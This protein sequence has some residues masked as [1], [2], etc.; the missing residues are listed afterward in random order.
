MN[1][2]GFSDP[3]CEDPEYCSI[4]EFETTRIGLLTKLEDGTYR[5]LVNFDLIEFYGMIF[6]EHEVIKERDLEQ[7]RRI[8]INRE[9]SLENIIELYG[10]IEDECGLRVHDN[11]HTGGNDF[12]F[13]A[14]LGREHS[15]YIHYHGGDNYCK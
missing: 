2:G 15:E 14:T 3:D 8:D 7:I 5:D 12:D 10:Y 11:V 13:K 9:V 1:Y 4:K 6:P